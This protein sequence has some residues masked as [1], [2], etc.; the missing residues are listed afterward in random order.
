MSYFIYNCL[1]PQ[2]FLIFREKHILLEINSNEHRYVMVEDVEI[3]IP[4]MFS[5]IPL[6][7]FRWKVENVSGN[8][9]PG[10]P[11]CFSDRP[12]KHKLVRGHWDLASYQV[13][14]NSIQRLQR[15][16]L[17]CISQSEAET[18]ILYFGSARKT[19]TR[20]RPLRS[21]FLSSFWILLRGFRGEVENASANQRPGL[22]SCF[23]ID[24]KTKNLEGDVEILLPV[25]LRW[26][27][28]SGFREEIEII[29]ANQRPG[30]PS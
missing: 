16:S 19:Q 6:S 18:A 10:R 14:L 29:P 7:G 22:S 23:S 8:Q 4:V 27:L 24:P 26:I 21:S 13:S 9:R 20:W 17:K 1:W 11:S 15:R 30:R 12:R 3:L 25:K 2:F 28:F 5:W